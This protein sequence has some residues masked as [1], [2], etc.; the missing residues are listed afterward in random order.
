MN[1]ELQKLRSLAVVAQ[2]STPGPYT[3]DRAYDQ[4]RD[5]NDAF[6]SYLNDTAHTRFATAC[7]PD[8]VIAL[9]DR[10][11]RAEAV[12]DRMAWVRR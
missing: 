3:F 9:I 8:V 4:S 6:L 7:S 2:Q 11:D 12:C 10:L 5:A 1:L